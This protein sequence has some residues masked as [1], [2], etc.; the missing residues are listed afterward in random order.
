ML[1]GPPRRQPKKVPSKLKSPTSK[2]PNRGSGNGRVPRKPTKFENTAPG[3]ALNGAQEFASVASQAALFVGVAA[4]ASTIYG[5]NAASEG[6]QTA[7]NNAGK[8]F[9]QWQNDPA[10]KASEVYNQAQEK[11]VNITSNIVTGATTAARRATETAT[12]TATTVQN[13]V[14]QG[15]DSA[16][17]AV[18]QGVNTAKN[19]PGQALGSIQ[20]AASDNT[21]KVTSF[22]GSFSE[23]LDK[24]KKS[25]NERRDSTFGNTREDNRDNKGARLLS[26]G[27]FFNE[28]APQTLDRSTFVQNTGEAKKIR[29]QLLGLGGI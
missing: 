21:K 13:K 28:I 23:A 5:A 3:L 11:A 24:M 9:G 8:E 27:N 1:L 29:N 14:G 26:L 4:V 15:L 6:A 25:F 16:T 22:F 7:V 10:K 12:S 20:S 18:N 2:V 19:A 17:N